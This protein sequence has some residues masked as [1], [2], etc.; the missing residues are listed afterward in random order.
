MKKIDIDKKTIIAERNFPLL[1]KHLANIPIPIGLFLSYALSNSFAFD[2]FKPFNRQYI[3]LM[4]TSGVN[5]LISENINIGLL[6]FAFFILNII[7]IISFSSKKPLFIF[8]VSNSLKV[9]LKM[10][11]IRISFISLGIC[12]MFACY[13]HIHTEPTCTV[14][15]FSVF[16][17]SYSD[18][19]LMHALYFSASQ[20]SL[21]FIITPFFILPLFCRK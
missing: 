5:S 13:L 18:N 8:T 11:G 7:S 21:F 4:K 1:C 9:S 14:G 20:L 19:Y 16:F 10:I 15:C 6:Y 12:F 2:L 3:I 17:K